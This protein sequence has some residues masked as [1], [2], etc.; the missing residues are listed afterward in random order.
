MLLAPEV[1]EWNWVVSN[2][3]G[4]RPAGN[5]G[6]AVTPGNNTKGSWAQVLAA[7]SVTEPSQMLMVNIN[8]VAVSAAAK[9]CLVD[10][11]VGSSGSEQLLITNL[12]GSCASNW[13]ALS[14]GWTYFFPLSLPAGTRIAARA[15]VNNATVGSVRVIVRLFGRPSR[16]E[17]VNAGAWVDTYGANTAAS[18]GTSATP[19]TT[20]NGSW[21]QLG[22][23][24][25]DAWWW[26]FGMG[27]NDDTMT[28]LVTTAD[29]AVGDAIT[30]RVILN[31]MP[32]ITSA[33]E[34][35]G[36]LPSSVQGPGVGR[37]GENIYGRLWCQGTPDSNYS[38]TA[39]ALGG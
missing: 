12:I 2:V 34:Q 30:K 3:D 35:S 7:A 38:L 11:G 4:A 10:I 22:T 8:S 29:I 32:V 37:A 25:R 27:V 28:N 36:N 31:Q 6:A 23:L 19:G 26:Q 24:T 16:R 1:N 17:T 5:Y 39:Y 15:S 14:G 13:N 21:V 20:S 18:N 9:D 33:S